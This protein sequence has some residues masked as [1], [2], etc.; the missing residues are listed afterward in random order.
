MVD[1]ARGLARLDVALLDLE[2]G[3]PRLEKDNAR[4]K[5][6]D[7][8]ARWDAMRPM[9]V[10]RI[11][12][13]AS[14]YFV[15]DITA[16]V[17]PGLAGIVLPK[18][19]RA[20]DVVTVD[21][22]VAER[23]RAAGM[24]AQSVPFVASIESAAGLLNAAAIARAPRVAGLLFGAEDW[25][26]D[27]GLPTERAGDAL[28]LVYV[29]SAIVVAAAAARIAAFDGVWPGIE[30]ADGLRRDS[31]RARQLGFSGK[32]C[33]HPNQIDLVNEV[34]TPSAREVE[35]AR[36]LV[37][38]FEEAERGGTGA[39]TYAGKMVDRPVV[40]RARRV[41]RLSELSREVSR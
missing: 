38:A 39:I 8:L 20:D 35:A 26:N 9:P 12:G 31:I 14:E 37:S 34:F 33:I 36:G 10:V 27:L 5:V 40:E 32:T 19:E 3:V 23:E 24:S 6:A 18:T 7:I 4:R 25:A 30:D 28:D 2:D 11:N 15:A 41:L 29:R 17:R 21:R 13:I 16:V 22:L 1:K